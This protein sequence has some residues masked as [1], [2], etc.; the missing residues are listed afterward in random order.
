[1][2]STMHQGDFSII[3]KSNLQSDSVII[4][5]TNYSSKIFLKN[6]EFNICWV[7]STERG[8]SRSRNTAMEMIDKGICIVL[9]D[10]EVLLEKYSD[11]ITSVYDKYRDYDVI[12]FKIIH[13]LSPLK[14]KYPN[15]VSNI[16][17]LDS[18]KF[19]SVEITFD[20]ESILAKGISFDE[21]FG[22]G[23]KYCLGEDNIFLSDCIKSGLKILFYPVYISELLP[24]V[25]TW[26]KGLNKEYYLSKGAAF[27]RI[28]LFLCLPLIIIFSIRFTK[29]DDKNSFFTITK[30]MLQGAIDYSIKRF[31]RGVI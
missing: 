29:T 20:L 18:L 1:M 27:R 8:L 7:N 22:A 24:S 17:L 31:A 26:Y 15:K 12:L 19:S 2:L 4:N 10:D 6:E 14:K 28:S 21:D 13:N 11:I 3:S 16:N 9:D 25:S 5:Q 23:A 30:F